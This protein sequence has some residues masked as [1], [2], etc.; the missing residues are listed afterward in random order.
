M[1]G[2]EKKPIELF[3][4]LSFYPL[5]LGG[6]LQGA[7]LGVGMKVWRTPIGKR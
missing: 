3:L 4:V 5:I 6:W 7:C 2:V 1:Q